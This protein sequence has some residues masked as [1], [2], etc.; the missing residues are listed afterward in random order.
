MSNDPFAPLESGPAVPHDRAKDDWL[1][2][3]PV[4][5]DAPSPPASH[6][7][8]GKPTT[9]WCYRNASGLTLGYV[10][11]FD[12]PDGKVFQ[13]QT[14]GKRSP[15]AKPEWRWK[16]WSGKRP[17][18]GLDRL[19]ERPTA[20]VVVTEGEKA[21]D[22]AAELLPDMVVVT[23]PNGS[24]SA[25]KA[26]WTVLRGRRVTIWPDADTAGLEY[27]Q[28]VAKQLA[29]IGV[30]TAAIISP[31]HGVT[32]GWDADDAKKDG[33]DQARAEQIVADALRP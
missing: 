11:R 19:A 5:A 7:R 26:D 17:L 20:P 24:K 10:S 21:A 33:W 25:A 13:P 1:T 12:T 3:L 9:T 4:P 22:A 32:T 8:Y 27:A 29:A 28:A 6:H 2:I 16:G 23:S 15:D 14:F 31:P 18:Y 30:E